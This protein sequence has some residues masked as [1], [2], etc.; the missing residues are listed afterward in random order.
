MPAAPTVLPN[1]SRRL[2]W[3]FLGLAALCVALRWPSLSLPL[4]RDE[5][6]YAT[7]A[8]AW[9]KGWGLPYRDF[10]D[11]KPPLLY[12]L[13]GA[14]FQTLGWT[15][16]A[17]RLAS[18]LWQTLSV[19]LLGG[20]LWDW[21]RQEGAVLLGG[22]TFAA[23][24]NAWLSQA[25]AANAEGWGWLPL[26]LGLAC[27]RPLRAERPALAWV[28][29]GFFGGLAACIKQPYAVFAVALP[30]FWERG[31]DLRLRA[32]LYS[33]AGLLVAHAPWLLYF[34]SRQALG[35]AGFAVFTYHAHYGSPFAW[36]ALLGFGRLLRH[37]GLEQGLFWLAAFAAWQF[38]WGSLARLALVFTLLGVFAADLSG[39]WYPHYAILWSLG[40]A[41]GVAALSLVLERKQAWSLA[42][43]LL[44]PF[45]VEQSGFWGLDAFQRSRQ[46]YSTDNFGQA[47]ALGA[48]LQQQTPPDARLFIW[49]ADAELY[50]LAQRQPAARFLNHYPY[51]GSN[52]SW[53]E[54][55][56]ELLKAAADP[57]V[58][59]VVISDRLDPSKPLQK[60][61]LETLGRRFEFEQPL[62]SA[63]AVGLP[64]QDT[65]P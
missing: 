45:G 41:L 46:L 54:A 48:W 15:P 60:K 37:L 23:L 30:L 49:G 58:G 51:T 7:L 59:A 10:F 65:H 24:S 20:L 25:A 32:L 42:V 34:A 5:G 64:R 63:F 17:L 43:L 57:Q 50:F 55:D 22:V 38:A 33:T 26:L 31:L 36:G 35:A 21:T 52:P 11:H 28:A 1:T 47:P 27:L 44:L 4:D 40:L 3:I 39:R 61:L 29:W 12:A 13:Y 2:P 9:I 8:L 56:E 14:A 19:L 62:G 6:T 53:P 18:L 16:R